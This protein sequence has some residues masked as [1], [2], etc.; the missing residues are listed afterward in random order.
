MGKQTS[1]GMEWKEVQEKRKLEQE[2]KKRTGKGILGGWRA[3]YGEALGLMALGQT[4][5][6]PLQGSGQVKGKEDFPSSVIC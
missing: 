4:R 2:G 5:T 3:V 1:E 6:L